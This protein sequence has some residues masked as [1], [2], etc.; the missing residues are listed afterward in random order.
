MSKTMN[1]GKEKHAA[2]T[3][4][5]WG[6]VV[7]PMR[8]IKTGLAGPNALEVV[9]ANS[10]DRLLEPGCADMSCI[11]SISTLATVI[12]S[13]I[14]YGYLNDHALEA[15]N[16][17]MAGMGLTLHVTVD[18]CED[19]LDHFSVHAS[20][21]D[22]RNTSDLEDD[23]RLGEEFPATAGGWVDAWNFAHEY[24]DKKKRAQPAIE[25][26]VRCTQDASRAASIATRPGG[27]D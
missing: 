13:L 22:G 7:C 15:F 24:F 23:D 11:E 1:T 3:T 27:A 4:Q 26:G 10:N 8:W 6:R 21:D 19:T 9:V 20:M 12:G 17:A 18:A 5:D 14:E 16:P 2:I 25:G